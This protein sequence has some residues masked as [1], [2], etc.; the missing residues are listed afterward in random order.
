MKELCAL[1]SSAEIDLLTKITLNGAN[2]GDTQIYIYFFFN[3]EAEVLTTLMHRSDE[4][5]PQSDELTFQNVDGATQD[6][7]S[8]HKTR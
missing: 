4:K 2:E 3:S 5:L 7:R 8:I 1:K 6:E